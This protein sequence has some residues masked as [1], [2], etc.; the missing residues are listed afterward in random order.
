MDKKYMKAA[1]KL[2]QKAAD[3]GEV[4]VGAVVV[5]E[6]KIVGR[7]RN[8]RE[9]KKNAIHHAEIE[10]IEKACKKLGGWRLHKCDLYVTLEPCP[11][12]TGAIIN[13]RIK[14]LYYGAKDEKAG[15]CGTLVNLFDLPYNHK[16]EVIS[17]VMEEECADILKKFF[18]DLRE[19]KKIE[20]KKRRA[21]Q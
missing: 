1:L 12:C 11:M 5:C 9:T 13:A 10:A 17:G 7:G 14:T 18:K 15:S 20:R 19:R 2:A 8:R 6:G 4:P 3:E 16:P 21:E